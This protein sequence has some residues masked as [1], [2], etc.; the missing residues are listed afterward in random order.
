MT[1]TTTTSVTREIVVAAPRA[2]AFDA[3]VNMTAW[4]PLDT[5]TIGKAPAR[6]SIIEPTEG[7]RWYGIDADGD[8]HELGRVLA[9]EPPARLVFSWEI[10]HDFKYDP[11]IQTQVEVTFEELSPTSTRVV[12]EHRSLEAYGEHMQQMIGIFTSEG[13]WTGLLERYAKYASAA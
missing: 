1:P 8:P 12:L 4:W 6:A 7:G 2:R 13:G 9:Y 11:S 10:S 5:H 3:F